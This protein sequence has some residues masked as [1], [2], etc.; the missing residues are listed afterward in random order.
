MIAILVDITKFGKKK[1]EKKDKERKHSTS[2]V[3]LNMVI[4]HEDTAVM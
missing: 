3:N 1:K 4:N 2:M